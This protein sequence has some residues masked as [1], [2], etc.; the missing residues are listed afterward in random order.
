MKV[1]NDTAHKEAKPSLTD[2]ISV[3]ASLNSTDSKI[4]IP[5]SRAL[6]TIKTSALAAGV[7]SVVG[8]LFLGPIGAGI[9]GYLGSLYGSAY[10]NV[11]LINKEKPNGTNNN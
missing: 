9:G 7:G 11:D 10:A 1:S 4:E 6:N 2:V 8:G 3:G 5:A